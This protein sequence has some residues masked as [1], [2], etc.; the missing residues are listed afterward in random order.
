MQDYYR[1]KE[2]LR[3]SHLPPPFWDVPPFFIKQKKL[4]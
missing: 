2:Y 3:T 4:Y 1:Y